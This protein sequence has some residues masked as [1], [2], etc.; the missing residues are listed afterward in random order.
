MT[1]TLTVIKNFALIDYNYRLASYRELADMLDKYK[2][3]HPSRPAA[4]RAAEVI[5]QHPLVTHIIVTREERVST[6]RNGR[7]S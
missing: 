7:K 1:Y 6:W 2:T 3:I 5:S 4:N